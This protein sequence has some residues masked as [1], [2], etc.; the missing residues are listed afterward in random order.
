[1]QFATLLCKQVLQL[2]LQSFST[3]YC[4]ILFAS[5]AK[6]PLR[7]ADLLFVMLCFVMLIINEE[8]EVT[9]K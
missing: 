6:N 9:V 8:N 3:K 5:I 2:V 7:H 1:L 4:A